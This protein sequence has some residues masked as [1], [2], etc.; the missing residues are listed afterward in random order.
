MARGFWLSILLAGCGIKA[1]PRPPLDEPPL[2]SPA[3]VD[4]PDAGCC[5]VKK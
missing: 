5:E 3:L 4:S 2:S 1:P